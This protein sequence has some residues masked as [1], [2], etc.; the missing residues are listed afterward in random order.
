MNC[1]PQ[2]LSGASGQFPLRRST[3]TRTVR[4]QCLDGRE[5][6]LADPAGSTT[7]W[8]LTFQELTDNEVQ[9]IEQFFVS[10][11]GPLTAFTFLDPAANLLEW[12]EQFN[13]AAWRADPL[14]TPAAGANDPFGGTAAYHCANAAGAGLH[15]QQTL[16][17]PAT[18]YYA[19]SVWARSD[20]PCQLALHR[21][22]QWS[23]YSV[24][25]NWNRLVFAANSQAAA[26]TIAFSIEFLANTAVDIYG[27]QVEAQ[28]GASA[29]KQTTSAAGIYPNTRF[30]A[31][32]LAFTTVGPGRHGCLIQLRTN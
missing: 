1:F 31:N 13:Q 3:I 2:L 23:L 10:M 9:S 7:Q 5:I 4:N 19:F 32:A 28:P 12:S 26:D 6:K 21:G 29:Y 25:P 15:L 8:Q 24:N 16:N 17:A 27:A 18:N 11:E 30:S 20:Q 22:D 14:L